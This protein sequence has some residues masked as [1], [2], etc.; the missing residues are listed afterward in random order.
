MSVALAAVPIIM[1]AGMLVLAISPV[2]V[3]AL[4]LWI[5]RSAGNYGLVRPCREMLFTRVNRESRFKTKPVI[6]IV[7]YRGGDVVMGWFFAGLTHGLGMGM[8]GVSLVGAGMAVLWGCV[9]LF[10]GK[11]FNSLPAENKP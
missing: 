2:L 5:A 1:F 3:A 9:G 6:D 10:L 7:A 4:T 11:G 8:F